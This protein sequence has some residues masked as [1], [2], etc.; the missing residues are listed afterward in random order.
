MVQRSSPGSAL[1]TT[2]PVGLRPPHSVFFATYDNGGDLATIRVLA[3]G[4]M[5]LIS[6]DALLVGLNGV[7]FYA[8]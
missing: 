1:I 7:T 2:L 8:G 3:N 4:D 6:G 5:S